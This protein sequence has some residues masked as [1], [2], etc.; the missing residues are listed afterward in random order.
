MKGIVHNRGLFHLVKYPQL[1]HCTCVSSSIIGSL[2][3]LSIF[4]RIDVSSDLP[5]TVI[6]ISGNPGPGIDVETVQ[7]KLIP[8]TEQ[9]WW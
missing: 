9:H 3:F 2:R 5:I 8:F 6:A 4:I 1:D 7:G